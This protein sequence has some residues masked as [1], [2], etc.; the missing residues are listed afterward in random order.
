MIR[1]WLY[2]RRVCRAKRYTVRYQVTV[3]HAGDVLLPCP[4]QTDYQTTTATQP[5]LKHTVTT[6]TTLHWVE[7]VTVQPRQPLLFNRSATIAEYNSIS[8]AS[9]DYIQSNLPDIHDVIVTLGITSSTS[10]IQAAE[11]LYQHTLATLRYGNAI[12]GL[13]TTSQALT[14]PAVDCGGFATYLGALLR[15]A[16]I[17]CRIIAGF[18]AGHTTNTMHAWLEFMLPSGEWI[19]LDPSVEQLRKAQRSKKFGGFGE[20]GSDRIVTSIGSNHT[21]QHNHHL[22]SLGI[23]QTPA[24]LLDNGEI[25]YIETYQVMTTMH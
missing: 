20:I 3:T 11:W 13:Y 12:P 6:P 7:T 8:P 24:Y 17:P 21:I 25:E 16:G 1:Q 14:L 15:S 23:L 5:Y 19:P 4:I 18:W 22:Y 9:D 10:V 2:N